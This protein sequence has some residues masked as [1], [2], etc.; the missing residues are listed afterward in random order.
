MQ[1]IKPWEW[2]AILGA[3]ALLIVLIVLF[4]HFLSSN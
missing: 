2:A 3:A 1:K 4:P